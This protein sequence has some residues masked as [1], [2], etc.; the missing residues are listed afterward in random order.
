VA[1]HYGHD[2]KPLAVGDTVYG[3]WKSYRCTLYVEAVYADGG[4]KATRWNKSAGCM[5]RAERFDVVT[6]KNGAKDYVMRRY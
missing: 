4:F 1:H 3:K 6:Y 2:G 5:T